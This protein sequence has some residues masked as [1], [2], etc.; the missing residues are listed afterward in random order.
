MGFLDRMKGAAN[1]ASKAA[2]MGTGKGAGDV[3]A[4]QQKAVRLNQAG[5]NTAATL[6]SLAETGN[7]DMGGSKEIRFEVEVRPASAAPYAATFSQFMLPG[8][9]DGLAEGSEVTVR[10]DPEDPQSMLFW[11]AGPPG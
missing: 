10:V 11:G 2:S 4:Y 7:T 6:R 1:E 3:A 9:T 8:S 5:V